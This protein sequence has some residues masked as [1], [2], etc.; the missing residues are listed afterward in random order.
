MVRVLPLKRTTEVL[1]KLEPLTVKVKAGSPAVF[2][3]GDRLVITGT[4][5]FTVKFKA[6]V[7]IPPPGPGFVTVT[8]MIVPAVVISDAEMEAVN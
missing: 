8:G 6:G 4:G 3:V 7:E 2:A 5:W 1:S